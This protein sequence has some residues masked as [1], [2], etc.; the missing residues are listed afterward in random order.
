MSLT[1][2]EATS[3]PNPYIVALIAVGGTIVGAIISG[4]SSALTAGRAAK[5]QQAIL[6]MQLNHQTIEANRQERRAAY[7]AFL[8]AMER[9]NLLVND[10]LSGV[11]GDE[12][13]KTAK[14]ALWDTWRAAFCRLQLVAGERVEAIATQIFLQ[15]IDDMEQA[16][17]GR[18]PRPHAHTPGQVFPVTLIGAMQAEVGISDGPRLDPETGLR[19]RNNDESL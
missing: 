10:V 4:I 12:D 2:A 19:L 18:G 11:I 17:A 9:W 14:A 16:E 13:L 7:A 5:G 8:D 1:V 3:G 15:Y 6:Q